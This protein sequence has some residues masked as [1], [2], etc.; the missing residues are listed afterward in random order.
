MNKCQNIPCEMPALWRADI[1]CLCNDHRI[2]LDH[3]R[4]ALGDSAL[5]WS[6]L[7]PE[8]PAPAPELHALARENAELRDSLTLL[9]AQLA[10]AERRLPLEA[11]SALYQVPHPMFST[12]ETK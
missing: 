4:E 2:E 10:A 7:P 8:E 9:R 6:A 1:I 5:V 11:T 12:T 3:A